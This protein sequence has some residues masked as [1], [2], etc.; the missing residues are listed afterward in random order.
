MN[1]NRTFA[2]SK[3]LEH[4]GVTRKPQHIRTIRTLWVG[5]KNFANEK[6][7][8]RRWRVARSRRYRL[9]KNFLPIF[10]DQHKVCGFVHQD[11]KRNRQN[12]YVLKTHPTN[13]AVRANR[14]GHLYPIEIA[15]S[16]E[17]SDFAAKRS[18]LGKAQTWLIRTRTSV[19]VKRFPSRHSADG[20]T[21][22]RPIRWVKSPPSRQCIGDRPG[23]FDFSRNSRFCDTSRSFY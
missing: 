15:A 19:H 13:R 12:V 9:S 20:F 2:A 11:S 16:D 4:F 23:Y 3:G 22:Y 7:P 21:A 14:N 17:Q 18:A 8:A 1:A 6:Q 10:F 5:L